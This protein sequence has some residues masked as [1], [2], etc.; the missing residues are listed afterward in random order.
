MLLL[1]SV[2]MFLCMSAHADIFTQIIKLVVCR[3]CSSLSFLHRSSE[4]SH[5]D[6]DSIKDVYKH[7]LRGLI[8]IL[9]SLI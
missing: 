3:F 9:D 5:L 1:L 6:V 4:K 2:C 8:L 7:P